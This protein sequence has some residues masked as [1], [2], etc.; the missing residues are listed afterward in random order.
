MFMKYIINKQFI[1]VGTV[2]FKD[3]ASE[4]VLVY[5]SVVVVFCFCDCC[6][7][8]RYVVDQYKYC[9]CIYEVVLIPVS[10]RSKAWVCD[11]S[12]AGIVVSKSAEGMDVC[13]L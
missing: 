12:L 11:H 5:L 8:R 10:A 1:Y 3:N 7:R 4:E 2:Y 9:F 13:L 6:C